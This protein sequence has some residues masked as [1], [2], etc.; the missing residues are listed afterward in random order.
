VPIVRGLTEGLFKNSSPT[1]KVAC[2]IAGVQEAK[3]ECWLELPSVASLRRRS[4]SPRNSDRHQIGI[5][6]RLP[7]NTQN[8]EIDNVFAQMIGGF[9]L[10]DEAIAFRSLSFRVPGAATYLA[11]DY[12]MNE[13]ALDF[14]GNLR[15]EAKISQT[16][17]GWKRWVAKPLDPFFAKNGSGTFLHI[18]IEGSSKSPRFGLDRGRKDKAT[19]QTK[20]TSPQSK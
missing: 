17:T 20:S 15:L 6:D 12:K 7:R 13:D 18:K 14:H 19:F 2:R 4:T 3:T 1:E 8:E 11:G 5:T 9:H 10:E 16:M